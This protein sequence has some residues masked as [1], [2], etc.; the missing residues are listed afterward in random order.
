M[1]LESSPFSTLHSQFISLS[2]WLC[3][4]N[5][6]PLCS[7][8]SASFSFSARPYHLSPGFLDFI[9]FQNSRKV[10]LKPSKPSYWLCEAFNS[11]LLNS[12]YLL[13]PSTALQD[14]PPLPSTCRPPG[15]LACLVVH[16]KPPDCSHVRLFMSVELCVYALAPTFGDFFAGAPRGVFPW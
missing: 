4:Q 5:V 9:F 16:E 11:F 1:I 2:C 8:L 12:A 10:V 15:T 3:F 14:P 13:T 6:S 7:R